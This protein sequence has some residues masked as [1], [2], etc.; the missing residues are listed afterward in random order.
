MR[1]YLVQHGRAKPADEDPDR[2]LSDTGREE[3]TRVGEFLRSL[4]ISV[5]LIQHSGKSRAEE[6]AHIFGTTI[7]CTSGPTHT[8]GLDPTDDPS[9]TANFLKIYT[10]DILIVGHLPHLERLTSLLMTGIPDRRPVKF[11]NGGVVCLEKEAGA[12]SLLW[13]IVPE[14]LQAPTRLAA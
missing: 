8:S 5:S 13:A 3:V 11:Q 12:W 4:R 9:I 6:T 2:G 7:R 10:D 1:A 14:L